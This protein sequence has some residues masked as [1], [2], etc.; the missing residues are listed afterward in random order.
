[1][2]ETAEAGTENAGAAEPD[3]KFLVVRPG[4]LLGI[5]KSHRS[6]CLEHLVS[7]M[8][9]WRR[10]QMSLPP[11]PSTSIST[12]ATGFSAPTREPR[13]LPI[14]RHDMHGFAI[15]PEAFIPLIG[16]SPPE[17]SSS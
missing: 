11:P 5:M 1:M 14:Y 8:L 10:F 13:Q 16:G 3:E 12:A 6:E 4:F 7:G 9:R 15:G 17:H 2:P